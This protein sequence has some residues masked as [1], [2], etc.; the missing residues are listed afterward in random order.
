MFPLSGFGTAIVVDRV[1]GVAFSNVGT[2]FGTRYCQKKKKKIRSLLGTLW[3][4]E[5]KKYEKPEGPIK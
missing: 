1:M 4:Y 2:S 3:V 5:F